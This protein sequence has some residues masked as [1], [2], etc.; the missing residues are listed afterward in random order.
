MSLVDKLTDREK[1]MI[2]KYIDAYAT[3]DVQRT[4]SVDHLLRFWDQAKSEY[5]ADMFNGQLMITKPVTF[6][7][8]EEE[9]Q[10]Q[11]GKALR[12]NQDALDF[13]TTWR[14][15]FGWSHDDAMDEQ[16]RW[17]LY[18]MLDH[19]ILARNVWPNDTFAVTFL[20]GT[21]F[22]VQNGTKISKAI[23]KIVKGLGMSEEKYEA[24]RIACSQGLNQKTIRGE[25]TLSIHPLD[26]MTMS[27]NE[28]DWSSCMN[29]RD[30]GCYRQGTV[31]MM[32]SPMVVVAY[33]SAHDA[34]LE[35]GH[36]CEWN[37]KKWR[38]LLIV[39]PSIICN[40][41]GYPYRNNDLSQAALKMLK[42]L[43]ETH[44]GWK[45]VN[46]TPVVWQQEEHFEPY[47]GK[48][49]YIT[50]DTYHMYNDFSD[51]DHFGFFGPE[52]G[53]ELHINYSGEAECMCCGQADPPID[54]ESYL[55][56]C[57]CEEYEY[58]ECCGER[59]YSNEASYWVDDQHLCQYC[60]DDRVICDIHGD[61]HLV[62]N[63][64][65]V[66]LM[67]DENITR[68]DHI[69]IYEEEWNWKTLGK[70]VNLI[71]SVR[72]N[73]WY[74]DPKFYVRLSDLTQKGLELFLFQ[75]NCD[76]IE[77]LEELFD[78]R[79]ARQVDTK[80]AYTYEPKD[81]SLPWG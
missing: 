47:D 31:E 2:E 77:E 4:A 53:E 8:G 62:D 50:T 43:A 66:F 51:R 23:G 27:D 30:N 35:W 13:C 75:T 67:N 65:K 18:R 59:I 14:D 36:G 76:D 16:V 28:S 26:Y 61:E 10:E 17:N 20:D 32:N 5:L 63:C 45:Y 39:T 73:P 48:T 42:Q 41:L 44:L 21:I 34:K 19:D 33:L 40:V 79:W 58:C 38:E 7:Q 3:Y 72:E 64:K 70:Y 74:Y 12:D 1:T 49:V 25:L 9:L 56:G 11:I 15:K 6:V 29:W 60:Y 80:E 55:V 78:S 69:C 37:S 68:A 22:K 24:F 54:E 81:E 71:Y 57:C 52:I 46:E